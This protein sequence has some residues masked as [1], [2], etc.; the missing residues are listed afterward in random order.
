MIKVIIL[1]I[2]GNLS[3]SSEKSND[4]IILDIYI[5]LLKSLY[6]FNNNIE[7]VQE[8][9]EFLNSKEITKKYFSD[10]ESVLNM[11]ECNII[12]IQ[13]KQVYLL[14]IKTFT[15]LD[16][17]ISISINSQHILLIMIMNV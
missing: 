8:I 4:G 16:G 14:Y 15:L 13:S 7:I 6:L 1:I 3:I 12:F 5:C 17:F 9:L 2:K 10:Y 11:K